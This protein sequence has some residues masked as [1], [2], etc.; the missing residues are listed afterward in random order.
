MASCPNGE[1]SKVKGGTPLIF[2]AIKV[3]VPTEVIRAFVDM[4]YP[5]GIDNPETGLSVLET[6]ISLNSDHSM[7]SYLFDTTVIKIGR[8]SLLIA[9]RGGTVLHV[10]CLTQSPVYII[11]RI[12]A[13]E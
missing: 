11:S 6:S 9:V 7:F 2:E 12:C 8:E 13:T 5:L 10:A 4:S 3:E 1:D